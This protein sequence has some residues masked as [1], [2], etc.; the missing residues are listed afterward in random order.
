MKPLFVF[1]LS[2]LFLFSPA[3]TFA[4]E[5]ETSV[6]RAT[7]EGRALDFWVGEYE[8][9]SN[10]ETAEFYGSN[11]IETTLNGCAIIENWTSR[12]GGEG[13]SLFYFDA[14]AN[15][16]TQVWVTP[17]TSQPWGLK[18]KK[19]VGLYETGAIRFQSQQDLGEG[20]SYLD[21]T[22]LTPMEDGSFQQLIEISRDGGNTWQ[23]TFD[24]IYQPKN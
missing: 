4:Q 21:R 15:T 12:D 10:D 14:P 19:M 20:K 24:A 16:W 22:T 23:A 11:V 8:V 3:L 13:K 18:V 1:G 9:V 2:G 7:P 5:T 6:C 17:D